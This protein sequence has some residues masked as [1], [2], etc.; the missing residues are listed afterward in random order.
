RVEADFQSRMRQEAM[1]GGVTLVAPET[2]FFSHDTVLASDVV[3]EPNVVFGPGVSVARGA[4]VRAFS[5]LE[6]ARVAPSPTR[7]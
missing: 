3:V 2:V 7:A 1:D 5:H 4:V 6:Q